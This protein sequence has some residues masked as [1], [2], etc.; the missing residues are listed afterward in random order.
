MQKLEGFTS[1][2][3]K[4]I[5]IGF[6]VIL[7]AL[8]LL[9]YGIKTFVLGKNIDFFSKKTTLGTSTQKQENASLPSASSL[10]NSLQQ[11][12]GDIQQQVSKLDIA[13]IASSSPQVQKLINDLN[14]LKDYPSNQI[15]DICQKICNGL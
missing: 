6:I 13:D 5:F 15:K 11:K 9:G 14:A 1:W 3:K 7:A 10:Q 2:N 12:L 4:R 8:S